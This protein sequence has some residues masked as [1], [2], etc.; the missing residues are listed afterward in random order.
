MSH[1]KILC[2]EREITFKREELKKRMNINIK[3]KRIDKVKDS[4]I[5]GKYNQM[6]FLLE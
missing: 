5:E 1:Q 2:K 4:Q 6:S 3:Q